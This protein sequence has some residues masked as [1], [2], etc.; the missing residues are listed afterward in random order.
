MTVQTVSAASGAEA[1]SNSVRTRY[2]NEYWRAAAMA[3]VYDQLSMPIGQDMS[4]L[5]RGSSVTIP[6]LSDMNVGTSAISETVDITP[7]ALTDKT[8]S[9]T[10]TSRAEALQ[11]SELLLLQ[12]YTNYGAERYFA[13]GKNMMETIDVLARD[14]ATQGDWRWADANSARSGL[15][16]G[17]T[18]HRANDSLFTTVSTFFAT[19]KTPGFDT[20]MGPNY[21][22]IMHPAA[23]H[24]IREDGNVVAIAQYQNAEIILNHEL[25]SIGPFRLVV[26]PW[27]KVFGAAGA[28]NDDIVASTLN[29]AV[30]AL[31][32][33]IT[34]T[35]VLHMESSMNQWWTVGTE[36]T[37]STHY[38][39]NERVYAISHATGVVTILGE[40]ASGQLRF[41]HAAGT[42]VR[43]ADS[44]YP[45]VF[46]GP[47]SL[48]KVYQPSIGEYGMPV[49][50]KQDGIVDQ[51]WTLGWKF[52]GGYGIIAQNRILRAEVSSSVDA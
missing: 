16:A 44:V 26:N 29:T 6:F 5:A 15:D 21:A 33:T 14:V 8:T 1:L 41:D 48:A 37:G 47:K 17:C 46:G 52:Y 38:P 42:A 7:Q 19:A 10:P 35:T 2:L 3:R 27:A 49:G 43:N 28:D 9:L 13:V 18:S 12:A 50:P 51:F 31:D 34:I 24:D 45:I 30:T 32:S 11:G 39:M 20:K 4:R 36:E 22:A 23:Y 25:G 40:G